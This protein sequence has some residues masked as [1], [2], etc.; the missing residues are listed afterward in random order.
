M[1]DRFDPVAARIVA[2]ADDQER[3]VDVADLRACGLKTPAAISRRA[4]AGWLHR[5][6]RGVYAVGTNQL[7][8][9]SR[10][11]AAV[12]ACGRTAA[13]G[14]R[15][16]LSYWGCLDWHGGD[17]D[18][19]VRKGSRAREGIRIVRCSNVSRA[20]LLP[21][22]GI[23][24]PKP[25]VALVAAAPY[26]TGSGLRLASR[27][28]LSLSLAS[29]SAILRV[30]EGFGAARGT[31]EMRRVLA[32]AVPTRSELEDVVYELIVGAGFSPP[33]VNKP[34]RLDGKTVVP[35]YRWPAQRL[36]VEADSRQWHD[37]PLARGRCS[38]PGRARNPRRH[39]SAGDVGAGGERASI[40][41]GATRCG[42]CP[43]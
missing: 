10:F 23:L 1:V 27:R 17:V 20:D 22:S 6:H 33:D 18:V 43:S 9:K 40:G 24:V 7:S 15:A 14:P 28:C 8:E 32:D 3:I 38:T 25:A 39:R 5:I 19:L 42:R 13:L 31:A 12:K 21:R 34:L 26:V 37:N 30:L 4:R 29:T 35:D 36:V 2:L 16:A 11:V 41:G